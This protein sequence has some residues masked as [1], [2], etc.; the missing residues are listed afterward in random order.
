MNKCIQCAT[1]YDV[2][3]YPVCPECGCV[4]SEED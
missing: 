3:E 4:F 2:R 1:V